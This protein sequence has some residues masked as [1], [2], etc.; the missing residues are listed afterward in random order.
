[1]FFGL[2]LK[3]V[4]FKISSGNSIDKTSSISSIV[5]NLMDTNTQLNP[6]CY[7]KI[8]ILIMGNQRQKNSEKIVFA[9]K[10]GNMGN[11]STYDFGRKL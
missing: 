4:D 8:K 9:E 2:T 1:M 11:L 3:A 6:K 10:S 7:I 5:D